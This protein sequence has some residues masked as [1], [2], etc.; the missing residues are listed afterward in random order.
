MIEDAETLLD[1]KYEAMKEVQGWNEDGDEIALLV[2]TP[3]FRKTFKGQCEY[4]GKYGHKAADCHE[5][6]ANLENKKLDKVNLSPIRTENQFGNRE[7]KNGRRN[8]TSQRLTV[9]TVT[10][11]DTLPKIAPTRKIKLI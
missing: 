6:K 10:N 9:S 5:R 4:C 3:H 2:D 11:M 7:I 1:N 8:L